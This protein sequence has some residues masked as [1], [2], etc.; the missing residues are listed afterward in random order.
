MRELPEGSRRRE[1]GGLTEES[2]RDVAAFHKRVFSV[3]PFF[4]KRLSPW[5]GLGQPD[6]MLT[7]GWVMGEA[8][9]VRSKDLLTPSPPGKGFSLQTV[10]S[11]SWLSL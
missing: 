7:A 3:F 4:S 1:L 6:A 10:G 5:E 2:S 8:E 11:A 9:G